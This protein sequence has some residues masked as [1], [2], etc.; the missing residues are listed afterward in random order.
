MLVG[1]RRCSQVRFSA[2]QL[3]PASLS[4]EER[5]LRQL[6]TACDSLRKTHLGLGVLDGFRKMRG[7][8][9]DFGGAKRSRCVVYPPRFWRYPPVSTGIQRYP[10]V[11]SRVSLPPDTAPRQR[12][13]ISTPRREDAT[14]QR[15]ISRLCPL[16][17]CLLPGHLYARQ[18]RPLPAINYW[19]PARLPA[20]RFPFQRTGA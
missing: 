20:P 16:I 8:H 9:A 1:A 15:R 17:A 11:L 2:N 13:K 14:A 10:A 4:R 7:L 6:A 19:P 3:L 18:G 12:Q 5:K